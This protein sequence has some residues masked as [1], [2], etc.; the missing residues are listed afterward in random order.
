MSSSSMHFGSWNIMGLN[1]PI[2]QKAINIFVKHH[3][4]SLVALLEHKIKESRIDNIAKSMLP[5]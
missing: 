4:L 3:K 2:K 5:N 1:D